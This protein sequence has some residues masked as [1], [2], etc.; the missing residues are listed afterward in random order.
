VRRKPVS[1][2][3]LFIKVTNALFLFRMTPLSLERRALLHGLKVTLLETMSAPHGA[4]KYFLEKI[5]SSILLIGFLVARVRNSTAIS[6][7]RI[8][9]VKKIKAHTCATRT[10][11]LNSC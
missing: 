7:C 4:R 2:T 6:F 10:K 5:F 1:T 8:I 11:M 3:P 9:P